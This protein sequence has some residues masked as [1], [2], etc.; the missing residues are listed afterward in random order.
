MS[1][2]LAFT[3]P[4]LTS[5]SRI[6]SSRNSVLLVLC[7]SLLQIS[8]LT[9]GTLSC[10]QFSGRLCFD[11]F[12]FSLVS[13]NFE[14]HLL[15]AISAYFWATFGSKSW[16][17]SFNSS[18]SAAAEPFTFCTYGGSPVLACTRWCLWIWLFVVWRFTSA[19][20]TRCSRNFSPFW[21]CGSLPSQ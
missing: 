18:S 4:T 12:S 15:L 8:G 13:S 21:W 11:N 16:A 7:L 6:L 2:D 10:S 17:V 3:L 1:V 19:Q 20:V 5:T 9:F 14:V